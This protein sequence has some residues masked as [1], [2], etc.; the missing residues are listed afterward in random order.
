VMNHCLEKS[1]EQR[2]QSAKDLA[3]ALGALSGSESAAVLP[4]RAVSKSRKWLMLSLAAIAGAAVLLAIFLLLRAR[5]PAERMQFAIP[6]Q[7]EVVNL[8]LSADGTMLAFVARDD[9]SGENMIYVERLGSPSAT[10]L[11]A[12]EG[13]S[14]PFWSPDDA[15]VGFF[16]GGKL[17]KVAVSGGPPQVLAAASYGR[18]GSWGSRGVIIYAPDAGGPLRRVNDDG[19]NE[20][21]LTDKLFLPTEN[22]HRWPV[23]LPDGNHF[24]FWAGSFGA[25]REQS[26]NGIYLSSLAAEGKKLLVPARSNLGYSDGH[27]YFIND[28]QSLV[29]V[30][31][32]SGRTGILGGTVV[33]SDRVA[34]QPSVFW[35]A[36]VVGG[37]DSVIYSTSTASVL[38]ALIWCDRNGRELGRLREPGVLAN[39]SISRDGKKAAMDITDAKSNTVNV[40]VEDL[41]RN[42]SSRF[43]FGGSEEVVGIWS[44]DGKQVAYRSIA[45]GFTTLMVKPAT[46]LEPQKGVYSSSGADDI[47]PNSWAPDDRRILCSLQPGAGGSKLVVVDVATGQL[48]PFAATKAMETNGMISPDGKWVAYASNETGDWEIYVTTFPSAQGKW[49]VSRGGGTE[50]RWRGDGREIYYINPKGVLTAVSVSTQ[51]TFSAGSPSPLFPIRARAPISSTDLF[52]YDVAKDGKRFLV[53]RYV[54]PDHVEPLT[55]VLHAVATA[56]K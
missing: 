16:A 36:F 47:I 13:A 55:V 56:K 38:S 17:K 29:T 11:A 18:G 9:A 5:T 6:V 34:Y 3:F 31:L 52:T 2:F 7:A 25:N 1:P 28:G 20:A 51:G 27:L 44:H 21:T 8:A 24:L 42:A 54:K 14:Y 19:T 49:Q 23:F 40:W 15:Y 50:P 22:S 33:V 41:D 30:S 10:V 4:A 35:G 32:D 43:T 26:S 53:N 45:S 12:T 37:N 39:P 46:G 48:T